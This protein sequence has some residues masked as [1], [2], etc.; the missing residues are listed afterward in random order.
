VQGGRRRFEYL[1]DPAAS[2][3]LIVAAPT[4]PRHALPARLHSTPTDASHAATRRAAEDEVKNYSILRNSSTRSGPRLTG[5]H[6]GATCGSTDA[7]AANVW[8]QIA[9]RSQLLQGGA[10]RR[11]V[12]GGGSVPRPDQGEALVRQPTVWRSKLA[13]L[14][15]E[16]T[17][18]DASA[19]RD[20]SA[21]GA[22]IGQRKLTGLPTGCRG[23]LARPGIPRSRPFWV[24]TRASL[25]AVR[26]DG[27]RGVASRLR[28]PAVRPRRPS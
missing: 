15:P 1:P 27:S 11:S 18:E 14:E 20:R 22:P 2:T 7:R 23:T 24:V 25:S 21:Q 17:P 12:V 9:E 13:I 3:P 4:H 28:Y 19:P 10:G 16:A 8:M 5:V 26:L 6:M